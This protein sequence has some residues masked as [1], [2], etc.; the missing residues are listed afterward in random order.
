MFAKTLSINLF[1]SPNLALPKPV[2]EVEGGENWF[3][4][5]PLSSG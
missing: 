4:S 2:I 1:T 3:S 5:L